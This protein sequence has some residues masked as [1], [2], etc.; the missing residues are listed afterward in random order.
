MA[1]AAIVLHETVPVVAR[2]PS[3]Y[4]AFAQHVAIGS[5][6]RFGDVREGPE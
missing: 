2:P 4:A 5:D 3:A 6:T 1:R